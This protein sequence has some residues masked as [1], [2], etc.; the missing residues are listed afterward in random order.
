MSR[1]SFVLCVANGIEG[2][3]GAARL[4]GYADLAAEVN[5][6]MREENPAIFGTIFM[7]SCSMFDGVG[8]L[9]EVEP[10]RNSLDVRIDDDAG[11]DIVGGAENNVGGFSRC[12]GNGEQFVHSAGHVALVVRENFARPRR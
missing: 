8:I 9:R 6:L 1:E 2:T 12:P 10:L 11:G 3:R 5:H 4:P 7:R